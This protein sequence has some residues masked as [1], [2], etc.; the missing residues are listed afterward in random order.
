MLRLSWIDGCN[1]RPNP[2]NQWEFAILKWTATP[3][4]S[5]YFF[6][7]NKQLTQLVNQVAQDAD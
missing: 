1:L 2:V 4:A 7:F 5:E 3:V 6:N